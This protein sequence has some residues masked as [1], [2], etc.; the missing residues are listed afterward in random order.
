MWK[1]LSDLSKEIW[2]IA[3]LKYEE[4]KSANRMTEFLR[5]K[6]FEVKEDLANIPTAFQASYG[7]GSPVIGVLGEFDALS[8][9][10]QQA[11][12][13]GRTMSET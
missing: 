2:D 8:G 12:R 5:E 11:S 3:E 9:L 10:S 13:R 6:R 7:S 1:E 4:T